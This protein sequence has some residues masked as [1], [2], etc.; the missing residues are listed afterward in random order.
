MIQA[1]GRRM[2]HLAASCIMTERSPQEANY[3]PKP[4]GKPH[5][6]HER[7]ALGGALPHDPA[8]EAVVAAWPSPSTELRALITSMIVAGRLTSRASMHVE[9]LSRACRWLQGVPGRLRFRRPF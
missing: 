9:N 7:G 2:P 6:P 4:T 8:L 3:P 5:T 1:F